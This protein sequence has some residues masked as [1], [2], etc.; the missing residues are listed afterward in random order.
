[1]CAKLVSQD[2]QLRQRIAQASARLMVEE[3]INDFHY[4]KQKAAAQL[5]VNNK[6]NLPRNSE[7]QEEIVLYQRLFYA[8]T[9]DQLLYQLR[10]TA[11]NAMR[12]LQ[13][14]SPRL[15]GAVLNGTATP[16]SDVVLHL[17][18]YSPEEVAFFLMENRIPY[19]LGEKR[20]RIPA[21]GGQQ[22]TFPTYHFI[23]G[24]DHVVL[25]V[26]GF[27]DI[28]WAPSSPVDGKSMKRADLATVEQLL[29]ETTTDDTSTLSAVNS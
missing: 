18:S 4:A 10:Q 11:L 27:D 19:E 20:Y 24:E 13:T 3:G 1:M 26:F 16:H 25:V 12:L 15:V 28:R 2:P 29:H 14:F 7:I 17:F 9:H 6:R 23:A 5:G 22:Q 21:Q 8:D